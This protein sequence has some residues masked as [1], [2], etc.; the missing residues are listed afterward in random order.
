MR[1]E[2]AIRHASAGLIKA[3]CDTGLV[4]IYHSPE[5]SRDYD[6][7]FVPRGD[8]HALYMEEMQSVGSYPTLQQAEEEARRRFAVSLDAWTPQ[9]QVEL[10]EDR[11]TG[12]LHV[13]PHNA[14]T[15][16]S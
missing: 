4:T 5:T 15:G 10:V 16:S 14:V 2:E 9:N 11:N 12:G 6:V 3:G 1:A 8:D 13:E 7:R